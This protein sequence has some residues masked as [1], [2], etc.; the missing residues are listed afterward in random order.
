MMVLFSPAKGGRKQQESLFHVI[1]RPA[2]P[3]RHKTRGVLMKNSRKYD[4]TEGGIL[5]KLLLVALPIMGTQVIQMA[6]NLTD[7]FWLGRVGSGAVAASGSVGMFMWLS[8]AFMVFGS[9]GAEIGVSQSRGRNDQEAARQFGQTAV[10]LGLV[11]GVFYGGTLVI[12]RRQMIGFYDIPDAA[13]VESAVSYLTVIGMGIPFSFVSAAVTG[14][15][16]GSGNSR[17]PF[18]VNGVGLVINMILDPLMILRWGMGIR[19]A[20]IATVTAQIAACL[21][22]MVALLHSRARPFMQF[23]IF[24]RPQKFY[25]G[26]IVRW[27]APIAIESFLFTFM[28]MT[29]SRF[30]A[31]YGS[32]AMAAQRVGSQ[33]ESM[34]WLIGGGYSAALTAYVGQNY[35]AGKW[36]RIHKGFLI[37]TAVMAVWGLVVTAVLFFGARP[38]FGIFIRNEPEVMAMGV[39]Y[40]RILAACQ[41]AACL[42]GIASGAFRG[43]GRTAPPSVVSI[44]CNLLR[45]V[46]A[47]VL[48]VH[49]PLGL[50]GIWWALSMGAG[51]RGLWMFLW[52]KASMPCAPREDTAGK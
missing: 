43:L 34:S 5:Q 35:G 7:M 48:S 33:I 9:K 36:R 19:G 3:F 24:A 30:V 1:G 41:L 27:V 42:E 16:N 17:L 21:L 14:I 40:I 45:V 25:L 2:P 32:G 28:T 39:Q 26:Q 51:V 38:L 46:A 49:T 20:A 11:L 15:F 23:R 8:M 13:V 12:F 37:S 47:Y 22:M 44:T 52:Y 50:N 4:L 6:Y 18:A 29:I 10:T 31:S